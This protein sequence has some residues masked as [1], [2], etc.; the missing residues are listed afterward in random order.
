MSTSEKQ[1]K[2][3][4][5]IV[6]EPNIVPED[7][8][9]RKKPEYKSF[10]L[11]KPIKP[12]RPAIATWW[13]L[14][15]MSLQLLWVNRR[16]LFTFTLVFGVLNLLLVRGL[17]SPIN[18]D[19][20][21][22]LYE[23][24]FGGD[25]SV[26]TTSL[27]TFAVLL[28]ASAEAGGDLAQT[29]QSIITLIGSLAIIWLYRQQQAG[30]KVTMKDAF[31]RGMYPMV[32]FILVLAVVGLQS[33]PGLV[34]NFIYTAAISGDLLF[35]AFEHALMITMMLLLILL[36]LYMMSSSVI[37]LYIVTLPEMTPF[38]ALRE[39]RELVRHRRVA[40]LAR[41]IMLILL[42]LFLMLIITVPI[43]F[44]APAVAEWVFFLITILAVPFIHGYLFSL[45]RELLA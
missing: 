19:E 27:T 35:G 9:I 31:Y 11:H 25:V 28:G 20:L 44:F 4:N 1:K 36:S 24:L 32:P 42:V 37:A 21:Q 3:Q 10:Q 41:F 5:K 40:V 45:Y 26:L 34:G 7:A 12:F 2:S 22:L 18:I 23:D 16:A 6:R 8:K 33:L 15:N 43:I 13:E 39:A 14:S 17:N 30:N 29:Y 38:H